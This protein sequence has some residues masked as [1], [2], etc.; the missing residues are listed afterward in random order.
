L[1]K[2][3]TKN[4]LLF[5]L[6]RYI[7]DYLKVR[8]LKSLLKQ[9]NLTFE[10]ECPSFCF[11]LFFISCTCCFNQRNRP[12]ERREEEPVRRYPESADRYATFDNRPLAAERVPQPARKAERKAQQQAADTYANGF[13]F[14]QRPQQQQKQQ[15][16]AQE[17]AYTATPAPER[18]YP[19]APERAYAAPER[20]YAA[21]PEPTEARKVK[22][23][24]ERTA[25]VSTTS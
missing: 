19:A 3:Y 23:V 9:Q 20:T 15:Q 2:K 17:R 25:Q 11:V 24:F 7:V 21:A 5:R 13:G 8:D 10:Q 16:Q 12:V 1:K 4:N 14:E 22:K 6:S 18:A